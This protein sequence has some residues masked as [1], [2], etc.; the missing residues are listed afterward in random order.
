MGVGVE[1]GAADHMPAPWE[2]RSRRVTGRMASQEA[3]QLPPQYRLGWFPDVVTKSGAGISWR[4]V[5]RPFQRIPRGLQVA[6]MSQ[7]RCL[8]F[9]LFCLGLVLM[10]NIR[11]SSMLA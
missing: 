8:L 1:C 10:A 9:W 5:R 3:R 4:P 2:V 11:D 6:K 7:S